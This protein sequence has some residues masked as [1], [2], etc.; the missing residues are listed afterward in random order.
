MLDD[1]VLD[2]QVL[3]LL[4]VGVALDG[5]GEHAEAVEVHLLVLRVLVVVP[6]DTSDTLRRA[7]RGKV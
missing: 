2:D 4:P 1:A 3:E 7:P 5:G 6:A